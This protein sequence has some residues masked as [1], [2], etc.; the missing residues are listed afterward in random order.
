MFHCL[1]GNN[2]LNVTAFNA[3]H[4]SASDFHRTFYS[5]QCAP[6]SGGK[7]EYELMSEG[8]WAWRE[9][10]KTSWKTKRQKL[11]RKCVQHLAFRFSFGIRAHLRVLAW[12]GDTMWD[13]SK[14]SVRSGLHITA[15]TGKKKKIQTFLPNLLVFF[16]VSVTLKYQQLLL[17]MCREA[18]K[19]VKHRP[20]LPTTV[21]TG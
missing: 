14:K 2:V 19:E 15:F 11:R 17:K 16:P 4:E 18:T 10:V 12:S 20:L 7:R 3:E 5:S 13:R 21:I 8:V 1:F 6:Q 9:F